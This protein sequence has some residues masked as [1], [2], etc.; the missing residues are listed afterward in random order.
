M[1]YKTIAIDTGRKNKIAEI[2]A[3]QGDKNSRFINIHLLNNGSPFIIPSGATAVFNVCRSDGDKKSFFAEMKPDV[4][5]I[6]VEL[7]SWILYVPGIINCDVSII[8][9]DKKLTSSVFQITVE[10]AI[11]TDDIIESDENY[12]I[13]VELITE[14]K[15]RVDDVKN[16]LSTADTA[17][18][19]A[20]TAADSAN[21]AADKANNSSIINSD[22][23]KRLNNEVFNSE[24]G[25][26]NIEISPESQ[27]NS[28][29]GKVVDYTGALINSAAFSTYWFTSN[30][31]CEIWLKDGTYPA[32]YTIYI[33]LYNGYIGTGTFIKRYRSDDNNI[34][35]ESSKLIITKGQT[36]AVS[37]SAKTPTWV[38]ATTIPESSNIVKLLEAQKANSVLFEKTGDLIKITQGKS[39]YILKHDVKSSINLDTWRLV[40]Q[41]I[42]GVTVWSDIDIE[43]V[44][45]EKD[46]DDY[47][48]GYH[49]DEV[50]TDI[51][52]LVDGKML[53]VSVNYNEIEAKNVTL[54]VKSNVYYC[55][56]SENIAFER[57]KRLE[58]TKN[59][60]TI[61]NNWKYV[62]DKNTPFEVAY[63]TNGGMW[64]I[65]SDLIT[66][67]STDKDCQLK[68]NIT[69][70]GGK[71][72]REVTFYG[73]NGFTVKVKTA[74]SKI[75]DTYYSEVT[76]YGSDT[77]PREKVYM[78][79]IYNNRTLNTND[80]INTSF[81]IEVL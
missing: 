5:T 63:S 55:D 3:K 27:I 11:T 32:G 76:H 69:T 49:G 54:M 51:V 61:T 81:E 31:D 75:T 42:C 20:N 6:I 46:T 13:L 50:F 8:H 26:K 58:F 28:A 15:N 18:T 45:K 40:R 44:V 65:Y 71:S 16:I 57:C 67:Y 66:G 64:A 30:H 47:I 22:S 38:I 35:Y 62:N 14:Y 25:I 78:F 70:Q 60:L 72:L 56:S 21:A 39:Q 59:N 24:D 68:K 77:R 2:Y 9:N 36:I 52:I 79:D 29:E 12:D 10:E 37:A 1:N 17:L 34:P 33:S 53:D 48:G 19:N 43:G 41:D 73:L 80:T 7:N 23:I 4:N 74:D